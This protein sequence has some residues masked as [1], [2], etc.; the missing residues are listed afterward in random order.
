MKDL[1]R[2]DGGTGHWLCGTVLACGVELTSEGLRTTPHLL[3]WISTR[4]QDKNSNKVTS[5]QR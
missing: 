1:K 2:S 5:F 4:V 3:L